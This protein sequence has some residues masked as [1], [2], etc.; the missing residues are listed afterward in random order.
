M[1]TRPAAAAAPTDTGLDALGDS[2]RT[3]LAASRRLRGRET[4]RQDQLSFAQYGLLFSLA[5]A[6]EL[7][8]RELAERADLTAAT[9]TQMLDGLEAA[10]L[11]VRRRSE[12]DRRVVLTSLTAR[13]SATVADRRAQIE[14]RW[15]AALT[16][17]G[18]DELLAAAA[19]MDRI[20]LFFS[21]LQQER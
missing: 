17:F 3:M 14:P 19:V 4:H 6:D 1:S 10:D 8:S 2:L 11:V 21:E 5:D 12:H 13:G 15:R 16:G 18:D 20:A 9:V 7:S